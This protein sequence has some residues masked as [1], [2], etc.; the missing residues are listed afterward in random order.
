MILKVKEMKKINIKRNILFILCFEC[1][2]ILALYF[3]D[4]KSMFRS[5]K[6]INII[7]LV[8]YAFIEIKSFFF[9]FIRY[10]WKKI[11]GII[12][13]ISVSFISIFIA[14]MFYKNY[15]SEE[16]LTKGEILS[17]YGDYLSFLGAFGLGYFI[18]KKDANSRI[19]EKKNKVKLL[20][21]CISDVEIQM[22]KIARYNTKT[23]IIHYDDK[24]REYYCEYEVLMKEHDIDLKHKLDYFFNIVDSMNEKIMK[25]DLDDAKQV[26]ENYI[27]HEVYSPGK[28]T[29]LDAK[30]LIDNIAYYKFNSIKPTLW[31]S[32]PG[33]KS[34]IDKYSI[35]YFYVVENFIYNYLLNS[36]KEF[37][38]KRPIDILVVDWLLKN[39]KLVKDIDSQFD[40]KKIVYKIVFNIALQL[41]KK[42]TRVTYCW[43]EY[44]LKDNTKSGHGNDELIAKENK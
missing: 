23:D 7:L 32:Q 8:I 43:G 34:K 27:I 37:V 18:Y 13:F 39:E 35:D 25:N 31:E 42:S 38:D 33:V 26:Y 21:S 1:F 28:Y 20:S 4:R 29:M 6:Y 11:Y 41:D 30:V 5:I 40:E 9:M 24:W 16:I 15:G 3:V 2:L 14:Y 17:F 12:V 19:E 10:M 44:S 22:L 36:G